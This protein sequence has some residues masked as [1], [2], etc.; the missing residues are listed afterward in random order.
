M[1]KTKQ[2]EEEHI[3]ESW[4]LPYA[5][6]LTLLLAL[7][8]VL[9][10]MSEI[11]AQKYEDLSQVL[12]SE[13]AG[14]DGMMEHSNSPIDASVPGE[15][16]E[17]E[18]KEQKGKKELKQL[19]ELQQQINT[20]IK[21]NN[22][23]DVLGTKLTKEG[24][25]LSILNDVFFD[26]GS[27]EVKG[28]G[29]QIAAEVSEFLYSDPP[30]QILVSGHTDDQPIHTSEFTS[31]W[32]LS[33]MRAINFMR[34]LLENEKLEP[35]WFSA[36]GYGEHQPIAPNNSEENRAMNRRVEVLILP[37]YDTASEKVQ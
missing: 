31:N 11:D 30:R 13:F 4:L 37:N 8:I 14:G 24:L 7:F 27:A 18:D 29:K 2:H 20:Y 16:K 1:R 34:L 23:S 32:D 17:E 6:M 19:E 5:D 3:G 35:Q 28:D 33:A 21:E 26:S 22:L 25:M 10:A 9:F 36:K 12:H 15:M